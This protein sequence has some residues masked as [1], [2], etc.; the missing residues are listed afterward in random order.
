MIKEKLED[1]VGFFD[2]RISCYQNPYK[3]KFLLNDI[4]AE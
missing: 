3:K 4:P 2:L 1:P